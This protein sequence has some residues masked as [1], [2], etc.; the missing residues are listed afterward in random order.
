MI[1]LL[2]LVGIFYVL[3]WIYKGLRVFY[4]VCYWVG[5]D[6]AKSSHYMKPSLSYK[7]LAKKI[8]HEAITS[9]TATFNDE[10]NGRHREH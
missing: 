4:V 3:M 5:H 2:L 8:I 7:V 1:D 10:F 9:A 6:V